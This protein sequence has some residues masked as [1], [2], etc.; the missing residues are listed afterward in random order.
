M[1]LLDA[2]ETGVAPEA[3]LTKVGE[4]CARFDERTQDSGNVS[5][6][7]RVKGT[8]Y[9][10][11]TAGAPTSPVFLAHEQRVLWLRNAIRVSEAL[12]DPAVPRLLNVI[13]SPHGPLLVY[14]W[15]PGELVGA[16]RG[17]RSDPRSA[18]QRFKC[19]PLREVVE[20]LTSIF[21]THAALSAR[22]WV[23]NDFYDGAMM[24]DFAAKRLHLVDLDM[25]RSTPF[26]NDMGRM[27]GST[28]FMAPEEL[29][30]GATIDDRTTVFTM[31]RC[32]QIFVDPEPREGDSL[33][34][35]GLWSIAERACRTNP[36][37]RWPSTE[38]FYAAWLE[39][40]TRLAAGRPPT[41]RT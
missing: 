28:R 41:R 32:I 8:R 5:Y 1:S 6:G 22:G 4:I 24:Y 15:V 33:A 12:Q 26:T 11:K 13:E 27:F 31:G 39:A 18:F 29:E 2:R 3:F 10:V 23:A 36:D 19:L 35:M 25:Y 40:K 9:F 30:R 7:I 37:E 21:R 14:D 34:R 17:R 38:D 20:A 16:A